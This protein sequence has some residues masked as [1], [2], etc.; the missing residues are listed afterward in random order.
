MHVFGLRTDEIGFLP[1]PK[2][3]KRAM[4]VPVTRRHAVAAASVYGYAGASQNAVACAALRCRVAIWIKTRMAATT[5]A[6]LIILISLQDGQ[7]YSLGR[8]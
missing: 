8:D 5:V 7:Y 3:T 6:R 4:I 1:Q 2:S